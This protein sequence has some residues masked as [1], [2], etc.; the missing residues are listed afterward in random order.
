MSRYVVTIEIDIP[1][2]CVDCRFQHEGYCILDEQMRDL[3][4]D[5]YRPYWCLLNDAVE[6]NGE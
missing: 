1:E 3:G 6:V 2:R 5:N 4:L